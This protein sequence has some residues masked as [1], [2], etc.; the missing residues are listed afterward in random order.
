MSEKLLRAVIPIIP[1]LIII[2]CVGAAF[3]AHGWDVQAM[4]LGEK[5]LKALERLIPAESDTERELLEVTDLQRAEDGNKVVLAAVFHSPL[6]MPVT[7]KEL[8]TEFILEGSPVTVRL[9][10]EVEV[11]PQG[12]ASLELEGSLS[13]AQASLTLP[14]AETITLRNLKMTVDID[15]IELTL[16]EEK[17]GGAG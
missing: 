2:G 12:S 3:A 4:I 17:L 7:I 5:P 9:A 6:N 14:P 11:P 8:S 16:E 1:L 10:D 15:G 13:E